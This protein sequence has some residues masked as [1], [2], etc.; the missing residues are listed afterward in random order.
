MTIIKLALSIIYFIITLLCLG[1]YICDRFPKINQLFHYKLPIGFITFLATFQIIVYPAQLFHFS[2]YYL[3]FSFLLVSISSI[4]LGWRKVNFQNINKK[5]L[6]LIFSLI[7]FSI[8]LFTIDVNNIALFGNGD[9]ETFYFGFIQENA[10]LFQSINSGDAIYGGVGNTSSIYSFS[11][12]F[13]LLSSI[14]M[15]FNVSSH[16]IGIWFTFILLNIVAYF[17]AFNI[18]MLAKNKSMKVVIILLSI[19]AIST[20]FGIAEGTW[21][22]YFGRI[23]NIFS[24]IVISLYLITT[25]D[26]DQNRQYYILYLLCAFAYLACQSTNFFLLAIMIFPF[27][28]YYVIYRKQFNI[29]CFTIMSLPVI[30]YAI[31]YIIYDKLELIPY[32][33]III[34]AV[35]LINL[36]YKYQNKL[37]TVNLF[38]ILLISITIL[39]L[40]Y[41]LLINITNISSIPEFYNTYINLTLPEI[42]ITTKIGLAIYDL[43]IIL[44]IY[45]LIRH[46]KKNS[47][48]FFLSIIVFT[49]LIIFFNPLSIHFTKQ[50]ITSSVEY[51]I[52]RI[53]LSDIVIFTVLSTFI[54]DKTKYIIFIAITLLFCEK[55][56]VYQ[57]KLE[58]DIIDISSSNLIYK[59]DDEIYLIANWLDENI[60]QNS[61]VL[62]CGKASNVKQHSDKV[63]LSKFSM[64]YNSYRSY[65]P[66]FDDIYDNDEIDKY[67]LAL[68][69]P[70]YYFT[71]Y[72]FLYESKF[73]I[74]DE[75]ADLPVDYIITSIWPRDENNSY[76]YQ[77]L[78][79]NTTTHFETENFKIISIKE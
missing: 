41:P 19:L 22:I 4:L 34:L 12:I 60:Q 3:I 51:R 39:T 1:H 10:K 30:I 6:F 76:Y 73:E 21:P 66:N 17:N 59:V 69:S 63:V 2:N 35:I 54:N 72:H 5:H 68:S 46:H 70:D 32:I 11:G 65:N 62:S 31:N 74:L 15:T 57:N 36:L 55:I 50:F 40:V 49:I 13:H 23:C 16:L 25:K 8:I 48:I 78:Y 20:G 67:N 45:T 18:A 33:L 29:Q 79:D 64:S 42:N 53:L 27:C 24:Y 44:I 37:F 56:I 7:T 61:V 52:L 75:I 38:Y 26:K 9:D 28:L 58:N 47:F 71:D 43:L 77:W 14:S